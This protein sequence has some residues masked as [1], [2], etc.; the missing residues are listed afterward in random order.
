MRNK[1]V[2]L[3]LVTVAFSSA[4]SKKEEPKAPQVAPPISQGTKATQAPQAPQETQS[5]PGAAQGTTQ[6]GTMVTATG[7]YQQY[8]GPPPTTTKGKC[9]A[10]VL[11]FPSAKYPGKLVP[12]P[13]FNFDESSLKKVA[14][15]RLMGGMD[16]AGYRGELVNPFPAGSDVKGVTEK[17]GVVALD[18]IGGGEGGNLTEPARN[19][20]ALTLSQFPGVK[21]VE[22]AMGGAKTS[23]K[24]P[25][26]GVVLEPGAPRILGVGA[27]RGKNGGKFEEVST[28][29]DRPLDVREL[30]I[31]VGK[32]KP[33]AGAMYHSVFDMAAVLKPKDPSLLQDAKKVTIRWKVVDR[34]GREGEGESVLPLEIREH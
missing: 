14:A 1:L 9:Y 4:C 6:T 10:F 27:S 17:D 8:F 28:I 15:E 32:G 26:P 25:G 2:A 31:S 12:F 21:A 3:A 34:K 16:V 23:L 20:L 7:A 22:L 5:A 24:N 33:L 30:Q 19:A 13:F 18:V 29:F 11:F